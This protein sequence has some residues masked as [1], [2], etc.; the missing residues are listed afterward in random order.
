MRN[1][2]SVLVI[3]FIENIPIEESEMDK[4]RD[5]LEVEH[6]LMVQEESPKEHL[7]YP[8]FEVVEL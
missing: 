8:H 1:K 4:F 6:L 7:H 3:R 2:K 5:L